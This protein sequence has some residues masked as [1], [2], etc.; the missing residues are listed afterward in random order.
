MG[1][2]VFAAAWLDNG[3]AFN[4]SDDFDWHTH[5]GFGLIL[6]TLVGPVT[7]GASVGFDG[8]FRIFVGV[9]RLLR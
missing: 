8:A 5:V 2:P 6:D 9:G 3:S 7:G 4:N 1:G